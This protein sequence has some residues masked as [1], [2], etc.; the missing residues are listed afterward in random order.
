MEK[1]QV[2]TDANNRFFILRDASLFMWNLV[3]EEKRD[4]K[5]ILSF[6]RETN[7]SYYPNVKAYEKEYH[8]M[9]SIPLW[10]LFVATFV[11]LTF[12]TI[13]LVAYYADPHFN[14]LFW[15]LC[16]L[17]PG[18]ITS[19]ILGLLA[20]FRSRQSMKYFNEREERY[21]QYLQKMKEL[22][23]GKN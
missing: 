13:Y 16:G 14:Q 4:D 21:N 8:R 1:K 5:I 23:D 6:E 11:A 18:I 15:F 19:T 10:S 22:Q 2:K 3:H 7:S 20:I 17:L 9:S 12:F